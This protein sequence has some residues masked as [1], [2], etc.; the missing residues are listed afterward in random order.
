MNDFKDKS[1]IDIMKARTLINRYIFKRFFIRKKINSSSDITIPIVFT[2]VIM[3]STILIILSSIELH[4]YKSQIEQ[5]D[6]NRW[7]KVYNL[8][9]GDAVINIDSL[10]S[11]IDTIPNLYSYNRGR[12]YPCIVSIKSESNH[13]DKIQLHLFSS[14]DSILTNVLENPSDAGKPYIFIQE[15]LMKKMNIAEDDLVLVRN[16]GIGYYKIPLFVKPISKTSKIRCLIFN[17]YIS[18][19]VKE[20]PIRFTFSTYEQFIDLVNTLWLNWDWPSPFYIG[21]NDIIFLG[22]SEVNE[23]ITDKLLPL[24]YVEQK[25]SIKFKDEINLKFSTSL[26]EKSYKMAL[27]NSEEKVKKDDKGKILS[28]ENVLSSFTGEHQNV[29]LRDIDIFKSDFDINKLFI[30]YDFKNNFKKINKISRRRSL[31]ELLLNYPLN[32]ISHLS[33]NL[34]M[35]KNTALIRSDNNLVVYFDGFSDIENTKFIMK[36]FDENN[37]RWDN[38]RWKTIIDLNETLDEGTKKIILLLFFNFILIVLF[39]IVKFLLRLKL[40]LHTIGVIKCYGFSN[41][42][43]TNTYILGYFILILSGFI[44]GILVSYPT[45]YLLGY[46]VSVINKYFLSVYFVKYVFGFFIILSITLL[47][48]VYYYL[49]THAQNKNIYELIKYEG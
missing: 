37:I 32:D 12:D 36:T 35:H 13:I 24:W 2:V 5:F 1:L 42:I 28:I 30:Q 49:K 47:T 19:S 26:G 20:T 10:D 41:Q 7:N 18:S 46:S 39:L 40:E 9:L 22:I 44:I 3:F 14:K 45:T 8:F 4:K 31:Q 11:L 21:Y 29:Q 17:D 25:D 38:A 6:S 15:D 16:S 48:I 33:P 43:I 27:I 23:L 34:S